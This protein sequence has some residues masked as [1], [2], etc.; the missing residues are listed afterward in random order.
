MSPKPLAIEVR[1][2]DRALD[3]EPKSDTRYTD[4]KR[5]QKQWIRQLQGR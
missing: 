1:P 3:V 5:T 2:A 4:A